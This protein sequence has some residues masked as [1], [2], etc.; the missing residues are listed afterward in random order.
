MG[1]FV[2]LSIGLGI[3]ITL[4]SAAV[5]ILV[6][7]ADSRDSAGAPERVTAADNIR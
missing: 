5:L 4:L 7:A 2:A 3:L 6:E 1:V